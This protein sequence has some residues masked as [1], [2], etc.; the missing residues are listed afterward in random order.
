MTAANAAGDTALHVAFE[1]GASELVVKKLLAAGLSPAATNAAG[2][3]PEDKK[4]QRLAAASAEQQRAPA[5]KQQA[6][7]DKKVRKQGEHEAQVER[8]EV[9]EWLRERGLGHLVEA[10]FAK[11]VVDLDDLDGVA[12]VKVCGKKD[13]RPSRRR[14]PPGRRRCSRSSRRRRRRRRGPRR[15]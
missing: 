7:E 3:T 9:T 8:S 15:R 5:E 13:V 10:F 12:P 14:A 11:G 2:E 1:V 6:R 4:A